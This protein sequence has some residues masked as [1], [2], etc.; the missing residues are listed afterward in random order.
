[1]KAN[2]LLPFYISQKSSALLTHP[3]LSLP[4]PLCLSDL[5]CGTDLAIIIRAGGQLKEETTVF[6]SITSK[7]KE[8]AI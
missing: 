6:D 3:F 4:P 8:H 2:I 5:R 7:D 1:V